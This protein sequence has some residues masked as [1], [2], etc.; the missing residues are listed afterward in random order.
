MKG[1]KEKAIKGVSWS[2]IDNLA[3]AGITFL[4]GIIL[5]RILSPA[6]FGLIGIII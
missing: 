1:L 5:A 6:E 2:V 3:N 4:I